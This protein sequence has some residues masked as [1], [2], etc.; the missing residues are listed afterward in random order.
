MMAN[1][2]VQ[3][4]TVEYSYRIYMNQM[5]Y[6]IVYDPLDER[7]LLFGGVLKS[8]QGLNQQL[9]LDFSTASN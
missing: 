1:Y 7:I 6:Q 9:L 4:E 3:H 5:Y 2:A 8:Q